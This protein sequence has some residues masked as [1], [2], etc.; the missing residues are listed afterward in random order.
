MGPEAFDPEEFGGITQGSDIWALGCCLVEMLAGKPP[1]VH[2][3]G[4]AVPY[5][6][7]MRRVCDKKETPPFPDGLPMILNGLLLRCFATQQRERPTAR[8]CHS[9]LLECAGSLK[10]DGHGDGA[11]EELVTNYAPGTAAPTNMPAPGTNSGSSGK[12][13]SGP[14]SNAGSRLRRSLDQQRRGALARSSN[15]NLTELRSTF[16]PCSCHAV[17]RHR[18]LLPRARSR[19][20]RCSAR[21]KRSTSRACPPPPPHPQR[22]EVSLFTRWPSTGRMA[23]RLASISI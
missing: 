12:T 23:I 9:L 2:A 3:D 19:R 4:S 17:S 15:S 11:I 18:S 13:R 5:M 16:R 21:R 20:Q 1:W 6:Q 14:S 8:E 22:L 10:V 7:I